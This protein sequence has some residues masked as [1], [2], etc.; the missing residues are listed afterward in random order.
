ME[1]FGEVESGWLRVERKRRAGYYD[2]DG[3]T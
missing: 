2:A 1:K 3:G